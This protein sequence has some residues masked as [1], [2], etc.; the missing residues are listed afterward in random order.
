MATKVKNIAFSLPTELVD[1]LKEYA[2][3]QCIPSLNAGV[4]EALEEYILKIGR[5]KLKSEMVQAS[6]DVP[7]LEDLK[8][9]MKSFESSDMNYYERIQRSID[10]I[11][12]NLD[13]E[14]DLNLAAREAFMS[15]SNF[16]RM[17]FALAG[18]SVKE[19]IRL[20]RIS[21]AAEDV[22]EPGSCFIDIAIKYGFDSGDS[23]ARA[24]RRI[25]GSLPSEFRKKGQ[26]YHF[27]RMNIM[28]K[29][30]EI[31]DRKLL[32]KYPDIKVLK[33]LQPV[34]VAYYCYFGSDPETKAFEVMTAWMKRS[35][36]IKNAAR[37]EAAEKS[38]AKKDTSGTETKKSAD[39]SFRVFG[40][41]NPSPTS[42][43]QK[44]YGYEVCVTIGDDIDVTDDKVRVKTLSGGL[45]A[46]TGVKRDEDRKLGIEI[47]QA[48][49]RFNNWLSDSKY[50]YGGHQWLEEHLGFD[51]ELRHMGGIDLYMP[52]AERSSID[53]AK[54]METEAPMRTASYTATGK[55]AADEAR[56]RLL[57]W[58][59]ANHLFADGQKHRFFAFYNHERIS[60]DDYFFKMH[61]TVDPN[62][63]LKATD[64]DIKVEEFA[65]GLYAVMKTKFKCNGM[66]WS[67]FINWT[68]KNKEYTFGSHWFFEEYLLDK[69]EINLETDMLLHMSI[70]PR[71]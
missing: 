48:W 70:K 25:T 32:D 60:Y 45:Y 34:R 53:A 15:V 56:K 12:D 8:E 47:M 57:E 66:S 64:T 26:K 10:F 14:I 52:I 7:F 6:K 30:F 33:E 40:Y 24:F 1:K 36:L 29:F 50:I 18:H 43:D 31:Q 22:H 38:A 51:E 59:D 17:F 41:N 46:V 71:K 68:S 11:E 16:Y 61:V 65:G 3:G 63:E 58:T 5:Q 4:K 44:E 62:F 54:I 67:E 39:Q 9:S 19:Y 49:K 69:H 21:L 20:R 2:K 55:N 42:P 28:D 37:T 27:E 23:F 35:G 13:M